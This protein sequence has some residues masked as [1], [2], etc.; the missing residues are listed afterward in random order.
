[1]PDA[2]QYI[3]QSCRDEELP[4]WL[5]SVRQ[6]IQAG[7]VYVCVV[8]DYFQLFYYVENYSVHDTRA[9]VSCW[10]YL[11]YFDQQFLK[12]GVNWWINSQPAFWWDI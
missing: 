2:V 4:E 6:E 8:L 7:Y 12:P 11:V 9:H 1:M 5:D 10:S 3:C